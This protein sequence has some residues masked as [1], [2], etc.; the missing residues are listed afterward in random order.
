VKSH[1]YEQRGQIS[2]LYRFIRAHTSQTP[3]IVLNI[4]IYY[5]AIADILL[6]SPGYCPTSICFINTEDSL[7]PKWLLCLVLSVIQNLS[8]VRYV[9]LTVVVLKEYRSCE[10]YMGVQCPM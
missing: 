9:T 2:F 5:N 1:A 10:L 8:V 6:F 4:P 3:F 7:S